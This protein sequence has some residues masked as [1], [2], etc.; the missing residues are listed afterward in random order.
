M[1]YSCYSPESLHEIRNVWNKNNPK[2]KIESNKPYFIWKKLKKFFSKECNKESCWINHSCISKYISS[3][4]KNHSF[5]P[6]QPKSW[7]K[8]LTNG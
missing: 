7:K 5:S 8:N 3:N 1:S 6:K 4:T 2:N